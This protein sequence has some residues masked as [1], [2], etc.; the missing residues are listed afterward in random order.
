[1][2]P[3]S[4]EPRF[5]FPIVPRSPFTQILESEVS[6]EDRKPRHCHSPRP[7]SFGI[8]PRIL[9]KWRA[10]SYYRDSLDI[11]TRPFV[12][13]HRRQKIHPSLT[14]DIISHSGNRLVFTAGHAYS[15]RTRDRRIDQFAQLLEM[16]VGYFWKE[17]IKQRLRDVVVLQFPLLAFEI[18]GAPKGNVPLLYSNKFGFFPNKSL[19]VSSIWL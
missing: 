2:K 4:G 19:L 7:S 9:R 12:Q 18:V 14:K 11:F 17:M 3:P 6:I 16:T 13:I 10:L 15:V 1:M 8:L 5:T